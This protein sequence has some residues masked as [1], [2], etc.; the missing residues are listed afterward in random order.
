MPKEIPYCSW[1]KCLM[2]H[3]MCDSE[4]LLLL[5]ARTSTS[6]ISTISTRPPPGLV[7]AASRSSARG[8]DEWKILASLQFSCHSQG[9]EGLISK[10]ETEKDWL[11]PNYP[12]F[13]RHKKQAIEF[14]GDSTKDAY[15][16]YGGK[17]GEPSKV[18]VRCRCPKSGLSTRCKVGSEPKASKAS[19]DSAMTEKCASLTRIDGFFLAFYSP[20]RAR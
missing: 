16:I 19:V 8:V 1:L 13:C 10:I 9:K 3:D 11:L 17:A 20:R 14:I 12:M 5:C 18:R 4:G 15:C 7:H 6:F 2:D